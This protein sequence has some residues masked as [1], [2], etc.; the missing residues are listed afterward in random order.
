LALHFEAVLALL[1]A[2]PLASTGAPIPPPA[3]QS[4]GTVEVM[5]ESD[6][7][8]FRYA[9][10]AEAA[11]IAPLASRFAAEAQADEAE[12]R[13]NAAGSK[14]DAA[15][16]GFAFSPHSL[17]KEWTVTAST[18]ALLA[19]SATIYSFSGGAHPNSG[20][21]SLIW[22]R[23]AGR[24]V[25]FRNL[26]ASPETAIAAITPA[27]CAALDK[28]RGERRAGEPL[29]GFNDCPALDDSMPITL[30]GSGGKVAS[31]L[32]LLGPYAAGPYV[33]GSYEIDI[34]L[35][36]ALREM[37]KAEYRSGF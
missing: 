12:T 21:A 9:Y 8:E 13:D 1:L 3:T 22:D 5:R 31:I 34:P 11:A 10:P 25:T 18:P 27:Y 4:A 35:T 19:L 37:V 29:E 32:I 23:R 20:F 17:E 28:Q 36:D 15:K 6:L 26:F 16:E 7:Y 30:L 33:E 14:A 2:A 24:E